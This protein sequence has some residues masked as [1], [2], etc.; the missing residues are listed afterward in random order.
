MI[1]LSVD[2]VLLEILERIIHPTHVPLKVE[3]KTSFGSGFRD[4]RERGRLF[5]NHQCAGIVFMDNVIRLTQEINRFKVFASTVLI[6]H[7]LP[8]FAR[9]V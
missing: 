8:V 6:R 7:P 3:T 4:T 1:V 5:S 2:G 9:V